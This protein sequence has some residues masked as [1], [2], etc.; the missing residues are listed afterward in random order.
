MLWNDFRKLDPSEGKI[1]WIEN[2]GNK[3]GKVHTPQ[4]LRKM[5]TSSSKIFVKPSVDQRVDHIMREYTVGLCCR[6][7]PHEKSCK[8]LSPVLISTILVPS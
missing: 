6:G 1:I 3:V 7:I 8:H 5:I 4:P 2:E